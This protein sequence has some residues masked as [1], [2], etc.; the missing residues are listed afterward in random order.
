MMHVEACSLQASRCSM[1]AAAAVVMG[2]WWLGEGTLDVP[3][4]NRTH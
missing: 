4:Y 2:V 3:N 1:T